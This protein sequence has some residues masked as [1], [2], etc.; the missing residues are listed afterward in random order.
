M[1]NLCNECPESFFL[2]FVNFSQLTCLLSNLIHVISTLKTSILLIRNVSCIKKSNFNRPKLSCCPQ[3]KT[4][5]DYK[6]T[7]PKSHQHICSVKPQ[8]L[9]IEKEHNYSRIENK[10]R[11]V[12]RHGCENDVQ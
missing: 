3:H 9:Y 8:N 4:N 10:V 5:S 2:I 6:Q 12:L 1:P 11:K 7:N